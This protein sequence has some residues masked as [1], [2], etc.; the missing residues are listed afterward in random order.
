MRIWLVALALIAVFEQTAAALAWCPPALSPRSG[1]VPLRGSLYFGDV[2][3]LEH[4]EIRWS[5]TPGTSTWTREPGVARLDYTGPNGSELIVFHAGIA[6]RYKLDEGWRA[7][8]AAPR[9]VGFEYRDERPSFG[10]DALVIELDQ[11][12]AAV[13]VRWTHAGTTETRLLPTDGRVQLGQMVCS[14]SN[15]SAA[16]LRIGGLLEL[17]A[18]RLDGSEQPILGVPRFVSSEMYSRLPTAFALVHGAVSRVLG[19]GQRTDPGDSPWLAVV[20]LLCPFFYLSRRIS[21]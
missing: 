5:G 19:T 13:R 10:I 6:G 4:V 12:T 11:P 14:R 7:P 17:V 3:K 21:R 18:I 16:E 1:S 2:T 9:A 8:H 20:L 15:I